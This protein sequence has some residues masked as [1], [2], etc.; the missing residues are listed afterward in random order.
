MTSFSMVA[1][2]GLLWET[3]S[4]LPATSRSTTQCKR[5]IR[6]GT[7]VG[8]V[9]S[10]FLLLLT[11]SRLV[12]QVHHNQQLQCRLEHDLRWLIVPGCWV[13]HLHRQH[14]HQYSN[15]GPDVSRFRRVILLEWKLDI[16]KCPLQ[17]RAYGCPRTQ[18][19]HRTCW[20]IRLEESSRMGSRPPVHTNWTG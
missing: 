2:P 12:L 1:L 4:L 6:F 10:I 3:S 18:Q 14:H 16:R 11:L 7:G 20:D 15:R 17:E 5:S 13:S 19:L 9:Q 8:H